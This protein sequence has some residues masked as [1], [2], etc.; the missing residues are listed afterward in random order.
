MRHHCLLLIGGFRNS[1]WL[2]EPLLS[3]HGVVS[4]QSI[5]WFYQRWWF[6]Q[7]NRLWEE[8]KLLWNKSLAETR[9]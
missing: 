2:A 3:W 8:L 7:T 5:G 1:W 9:I 6:A 4:G